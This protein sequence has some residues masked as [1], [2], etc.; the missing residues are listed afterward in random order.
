MKI[1]TLFVD[2]G[3]VL[4]TNGWEHQSRKLASMKFNLDLNEMEVRHNMFFDT[5][6]LGKISLDLY[7]NC[8]IFYQK[9]SFTQDEFK[10]YMFDQSQPYPQMIELI[11]KLKAK[12]SLKIVA[13]NNEAQDLNAYRIKTFKLDSLIDFFVSSCFVHL[14]KPDP[15]IFRIALEMAQVPAE[16]IIYIEDRAL[17]V[18]LASELGIQGICH[19]NCESTAKKL[20]SYGLKL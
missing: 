16:Q 20:T 8:V 15:D 17:F 10:K 13:V 19:T 12:Y 1:T 5:Y 4:L 3:G 2:I 9:R 14:R 11:S 6:E 18:Q 7:L